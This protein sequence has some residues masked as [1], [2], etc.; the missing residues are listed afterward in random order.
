VRRGLGWALIALAVVL[1]VS[2][3]AFGPLSDSEA[4]GLWV[5]AAIAAVVGAFLAAMGSRRHPARG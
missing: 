2:P 5:L 3:W 1:A 4:Q